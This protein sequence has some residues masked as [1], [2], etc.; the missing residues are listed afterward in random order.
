MG[1]EY[2]FVYPR[3]VT[4]LREAAADNTPEGAVDP[5]WTP[6]GAQAT[7]GPGKSANFSPPFPAY[8][9]G[10]ATFG[11][12]LFRAMALY[13]QSA[14]EK[15]FVVPNPPLTDAFP[16]AGV[17]FRFVSDEYNNRNYGAGQTMPRQYVQVGFTRSSR[18]RA[19]TP[20]AESI[21]ASTGTSTPTTGSP[22]VLPLPKTR[23]GSSSSLETDGGRTY[24]APYEA[25]SRCGVGSLDTLPDGGTHHVRPLQQGILTVDAGMDD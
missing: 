5:L 11:G 17:P 19:P 25:L 21:S 4:Y 9:S 8:P 16:D 10:H 1:G 12:A 22:W 13:F 20:T 6:L 23:S 15:K 14:V 2:F 3:P 24:R 18:P 7:N